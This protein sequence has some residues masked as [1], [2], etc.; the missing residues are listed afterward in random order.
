MAQAVTGL[1]QPPTR[2]SY[3]EQGGPNPSQTYMFAWEPENPGQMKPGDRSYDVSVDA[4]RGVV[5]HFGS[6]GPA[7]PER[8]EAAAMS[9]EAA[10][11]VAER[12]LVEVRPD[13]APNL[14]H[15]PADEYE[16]CRLPGAAEEEGDERSLCNRY[17]FR[18]QRL[19]HGIPLEDGSV[20]VEVDP[21]SGRVA[22]FGG[23]EPGNAEELAN[24]PEPKGVIAAGEALDQLLAAAELRLTWQVFWP[25]YHIMRKQGREAE[26]PQ[27]VLVYAPA[28]PDGFSAIDAFTG[29]LLDHQGQDLNLLALEPRDIE[30]HWAQK[31][32]E[33]L[34]LRRVLSLE[35]DGNFYPDRAVTRGEA[36]RWLVLAKG[37]RPYVVRGKYS[38]MDLGRGGEGAPQAAAAYAETALRAGIVFKE[39]LGENFEPERPLSR[40]EFALWA[41]R[42][43]GYGAIARMDVAIPL[44][45]TD[46]EAIGAPYRNAVAIL[47]GLKVIQREGAFRPE[48]TITRAEAARILFAVA[49]ERRE[50]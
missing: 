14:A 3:S 32:I 35:A 27:P 21:W 28:M 18:F 25:D 19:V 30:G 26:L 38:F 2:V 10:R 40:Q 11:E 43:M 7:P 31:E 37:L 34:L 41:V 45:Y 29:H 13:L 1:Q 16:W 5:Q 48:D 6:W 50:R 49:S 17:T 39:E 33:L 15:L 20:H 46:A 12:F 22:Y 9:L 44:S 42:A 23:G 4:I 24:L 47:A 36:A 8:D